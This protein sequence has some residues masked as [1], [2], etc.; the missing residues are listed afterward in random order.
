MELVRKFVLAQLLFVWWFGF[1]GFFWGVGGLVGGIN[2][3]FVN[4]TIKQTQ[5]KVMDLSKKE[6]TRKEKSR[7]VPV[8]AF[9]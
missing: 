7:N 1:C 8:I 2:I 5:I 9:S 4:I 6:P 3:F